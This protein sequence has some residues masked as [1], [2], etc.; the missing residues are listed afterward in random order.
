MKVD[1]FLTS[2]TKINL[3]WIKAL[4]VRPEN[5]KFL[6]ENLGNKLFDI[7]LNNMFWPVFSARATNL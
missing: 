7:D 6:E 2:C 5:I 4:N 1:H 3:K